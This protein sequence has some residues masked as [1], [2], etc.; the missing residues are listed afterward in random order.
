VATG[1]GVSVDD[2]LRTTVPGIVAAGDVAEAADRMTGEHFVHAIFPNA[3]TQGPIAAANLLGAHRRYA[4]A[5]AMNSLKHL[6]V[7]IVAVGTTDGPDEV[8]RFQEPGIIRSVYLAGGRIIGAQLAGDVRAAGIYR[9]L[10]L[11]RVDVTRFGRRLVEPGFSMADVVWDAL[12]R[13][14]AT[15]E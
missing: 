6:G 11:R 9:S 2:E 12:E 14:P 7:P 13:V 10:M 8:L 4:G 1:W 15:V 3:V 5:E